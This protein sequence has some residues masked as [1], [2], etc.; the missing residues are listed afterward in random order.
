MVSKALTRPCLAVG[1]LCCTLRPPDG[2]SVTVIPGRKSGDLHRIVGYGTENGED[3]WIPLK[4]FLDDEAEL[5]LHGPAQVGRAKEFEAVKRAIN[6]VSA[7]SNSDILDHI[8]F[9]SIKSCR[10]CKGGAIAASFRH[11]IEGLDTGKIYPYSGG[12]VRLSW[13][14]ELI[15][16]VL[17]VGYGTENGE[18]YWIPLEIFVDDEAELNLHGPVQVGRAK[19]FEAVERAIS[20]VS[21]GSN[22]DVLDH[23]AMPCRRVPVLHTPV[24]RRAVR[25]S[26]PRKKKVVFIDFFVRIPEGDENEL[27]KAVKRQPVATCIAIN[28]RSCTYA[29]GIVRQSW[30]EELNQVVLIVGYGTENGEDY[31]IVRNSWGKKWGEGGYSRLLRNVGMCGISLKSYYRIIEQF[32]YCQYQVTH[33]AI[34]GIDVIFQWDVGMIITMAK[35]KDLF[36]L[37]NVRHLILHQCVEF[38]RSMPLEIFVDDMYSVNEA[39]EPNNLLVESNFPSISI[40]FGVSQEG[41]LAQNKGS[42]KKHKR[43]L[44]ATE[45]VNRGIH[46][47][48]VKVVINYDMPDSACTYLQRVGRAKEFEAVERAI[49][50]VSAGSN[51][52]VLDHIVCMSIKSC[53]L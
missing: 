36:N 34:I 35:D 53:R 26:N 3:Y 30:G 8:V 1:S 15:H 41:R 39:V 45:L 4:I 13:G 24:S 14:E 27:K 23:I 31:W 10:G 37:K 28:F 25:Y 50:F 46:I 48:G 29:G 16:V 5:N 6:F 33:P 49:N 43:I 20:F 12:I 40:H 17:I 42:E 7:G 32:K 47:K 52:D 19:E 51:S 2:R 21:A 38:W 44:V 18:D 22:S 9:M 11:I